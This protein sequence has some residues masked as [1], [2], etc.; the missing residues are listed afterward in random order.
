MSIQSADKTGAGITQNPT[1]R[2]AVSSFHSANQVGSAGRDRSNNE[3]VLSVQHVKKR[4][5]RKMIIHDVTFDVRAGEIFGFLGP[6]GAGK[7]RLFVCW[8]I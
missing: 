8:S 2:D 4:I 3:T 6:N 5:K 7:R 1:S